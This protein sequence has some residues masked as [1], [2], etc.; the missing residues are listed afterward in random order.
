[1]TFVATACAAVAVLAASEALWLA[2]LA[3]DACALF[4]AVS[5]TVSLVAL[6]SLAAIE[7][8]NA[9]KAALA[10]LEPAFRSTPAD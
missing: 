3:Y 6:A 10:A 5:V 1:M 7:L 2:A 8:F 9:S 4:C